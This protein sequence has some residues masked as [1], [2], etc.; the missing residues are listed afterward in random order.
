MLTHLMRAETETH[1][2][3]RVAWVL[4]ILN[5]SL[6]PWF[7]A[8]VWF[9]PDTDFWVRLSVGYGALTIGFIGGVRGGFAF[10]DRERL[11]TWRDYAVAMAHPLT[12][13]LALIPEPMAGCALLAAAFC[14]SAFL[15]HLA[16]QSGALPR[17]YG[18]NRL[19]FVGALVA[20]M[21]AVMAKL[22]VDKGWF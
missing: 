8:A 1:R 15:D 14:M 10:S 18:R 13:W 20:F 16:A 2:T 12:G 22:A 4:A 5:V 19:Q 21:L 17:W 7:A 3:P 11:P 6:M 9:A